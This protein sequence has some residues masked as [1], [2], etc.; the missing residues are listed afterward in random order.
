MADSGNQ[1]RPGGKGQ[2]HRHGGGSRSGSQPQ[3]QKN[4]RES[5]RQL[6]VLEFRRPIQSRECAIC[7]KP[8]FDLAGA[9]GD[10]E[11]GEP[12]HFDC[13]FERV[14]A[15]ETLAEGEKVVYLGA[16]N[17]AVVS[18]KN[19]N[20]GAFVVKRRIRWEKEGEKKPWRKEISSYIAK[21]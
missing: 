9:I 8:I 14:S 7:Q 5:A 13:A 16:G 19:G 21:I 18:F 12:V 3:A 6:P 2:Q 4:A 11:T 15:A 1:R 17:F 20:D 10:R